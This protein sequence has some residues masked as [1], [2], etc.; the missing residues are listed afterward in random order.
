MRS[1]CVTRGS[2]SR[3]A[4]GRALPPWGEAEATGLTVGTVAD[5][6]TGRSSSRSCCPI[7]CSAGLQGACQRN[8][9]PGRRC[10]LRT[11]STSSTSGSPAAGHDVIM[12]APKGPGHVVSRALHRGLRHSGAD[13][14]RAGRIRQRARARPR[15]RDRDRRRSGR[16]PRDDL[17]GGDRDRPFRRAGRPLRRYLRARPG[18]IRDPRRRR[19]RPRR[20]PTTSASTS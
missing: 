18:G 11:A 12:V 10:C 17:Q 4:C 13:R 6:I 9:A 7:R 20:S 14:G 2:R 1:T 15:L 19:L 3:W 8:L 16:H 5:A